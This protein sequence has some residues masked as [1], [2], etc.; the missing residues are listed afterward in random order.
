MV[1]CGTSGRAEI[2][3]ALDRAEKLVASIEARSVSPRILELRGRLAVALG[4]TSGAGQALRAAR[5]LYRAVKC[6][7]PRRTPGEPSPPLVT[8][9]YLVA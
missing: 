7:R 5:D 9:W 1:S 4:D 8:S 2:E 6:H 3:A